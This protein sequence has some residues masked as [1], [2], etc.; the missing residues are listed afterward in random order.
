MLYSILGIM[1]N[2]EVKTSVT[3]YLDNIFLVGGLLYM[4]VSIITVSQRIFS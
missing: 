1:P 3:G 4:K 2:K